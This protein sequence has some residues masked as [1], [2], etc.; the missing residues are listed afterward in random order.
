MKLE[1]GNKNIIITLE[2]A[3]LSD[4]SEQ[5]LI[6]IDL[7]ELLGYKVMGV[8]FVTPN[9]NK[10]EELNDTLEKSQFI[11]PESVD[12]NGIAAE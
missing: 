2:V 4:T 10:K 12:V 7:F 1:N 5:L 3:D 8:P 11:L 9:S 6:G